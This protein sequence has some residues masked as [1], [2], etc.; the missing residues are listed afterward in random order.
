MRVGNILLFAAKKRYERRLCDVPA[1]S[2]HRWLNADGWFGLRVQSLQEIAKLTPFQQRAL[3]WWAKSEADR[4]GGEGDYRAVVYDTLSSLTAMEGTAVGIWK[5]LMALPPAAQLRALSG[6]SVAVNDFARMVNLPTEDL[7]P[8]FFPIDVAQ[9]L[10]SERIWL[11]T[12]RAVTRHWACQ[13]PRLES[14]RCLGDLWLSKPGES[15]EAFRGWLQE[16]EKVR[17]T[18]FVQVEVETV[19]LRMGAGNRVIVEPEIQLAR[20]RRNV[21]P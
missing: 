4:F 11:Q 15:L 19:T 3:G 8:P 5:L 16:N 20:F 18:L 21:A 1:S 10:T 12:Q 17:N 6:Q 9:A 13:K 2:I 7:I 14:V